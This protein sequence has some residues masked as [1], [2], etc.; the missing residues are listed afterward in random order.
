MVLFCSSFGSR[1][2]WPCALQLLIKMLIRWCLVWGLVLLCWNFL[3]KS[4][5]TLILQLFHLLPFPFPWLLNDS[6]LTLFLLGVVIKGVAHCQVFPGYVPQRHVLCF[7]AGCIP[8]VV[9]ETGAAEHW[10]ELPFPLLPVS[11]KTTLIN[12]VGLTLT[13]HWFD[14]SITL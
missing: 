14:I 8:L 2:E 6:F 1:S 11:I 10:A 12:N 7:H 3:F 4:L 9:M 13:Q 5:N